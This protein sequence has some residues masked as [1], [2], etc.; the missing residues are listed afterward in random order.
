MS[1]FID[2]LQRQLQLDSFQTSLLV[3][4]LG[5]QDVDELNDDDSDDDKLGTSGMHLHSLK[6]QTNPTSQ[7]QTYRQAEITLGMQ[8][9]IVESH[10]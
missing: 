2:S 1:H 5:S 8:L 9:Q 10:T 3:Q 7:G 4:I 6:L